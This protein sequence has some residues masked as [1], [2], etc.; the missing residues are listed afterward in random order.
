MVY[1]EEM[2][3]ALYVGRH[4]IEGRIATGGYRL[5]DVLNDPLAE[6]LQDQ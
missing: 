3:L 2:T 5:L 4:T 6:Y 1:R